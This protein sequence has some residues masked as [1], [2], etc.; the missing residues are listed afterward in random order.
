PLGWSAQALAARHA[1]QGFQP[2]YV[3]DP[4]VI[5]NQPVDEPIRLLPGVEWSV[6]AQHVVALGAVAPIDRGGYNR[7]TPAMLGLFAELHRQGALGLA[8]LPEYLEH[9]WCDLP[10]FVVAGVDGLV[11]VDCASRA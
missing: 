5:F 9:L 8:S 10:E 11:V 6:Y 1:A 2:S 4:N 7:D 3:T